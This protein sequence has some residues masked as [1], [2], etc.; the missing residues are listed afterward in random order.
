MSSHVPH[1]PYAAGHP[2]RAKSSSATTRMSRAK[3]TLQPPPPSPPLPCH[4][5]STFAGG[6]LEAAPVE[7]VESSRVAD[8]HLLQSTD[9]G[10][11]SRVADEHLLHQPSTPLL[12]QGGVTKGGEAIAGS[13]NQEAVSAALAAWHAAS[14]LQNA[15]TD[16]PKP[17][18][19]SASDCSEPLTKRK[20]ELLEEAQGVPGST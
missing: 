2:F 15:N 6:L 18:W 14:W 10:E 4:A 17:S 11:S 8:E 7:A 16:L 19:P 5:T 20:I 3:G 12:P 13:S 9:G 1:T